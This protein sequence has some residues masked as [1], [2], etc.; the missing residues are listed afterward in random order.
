MFPALHDYILMAGCLL[1]CLATIALAHRV[2]RQNT[3]VKAARDAEL[4]FHTLAEAIPQI[5]WTTGPDG[6]T[7]YINKRWYEMTGTA[8]KGSLGS[9]WMEAVHPDDRDACRKKWKECLRAGEPFEIEYRLHDAEK[10]YRWYL[11]RAVPLRDASGATIKWFGT[12]TDIDDQMHTQQLLEEQIKEHTEALFEANERLRQESLHDPLTGLYNRRYLEDVLERETRRAV[13]AEH[14]LS[15]IMLDLDHFKRF[16]DTYG[17]DAGDTV[18]RE[19]ATLLL[20]SVRAED[21]VCRYGGEEFIII[22]PMAAFRIAYA[23][24]ERIREKVHELTLVCRGQKVGEI[25]LS[26]GVAAL[27]EHGVVPAQLLQAADAALYRAKSEG[28]DC[29]VAAQGSEG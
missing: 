21:I 26:A 28:R 20:K 15:V 17:H 25:T 5:V 23:R 22:L 12:C 7:T 8:V 1:F 16:N 6:L 3:I 29:V 2:S 14:G 13:R 19:A 10:G 9:G 4:Q 27:P 24:A 18:L 11:D